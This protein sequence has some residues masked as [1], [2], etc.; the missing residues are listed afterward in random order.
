MNRDR[1]HFCSSPASIRVFLVNDRSHLRML[2]LLTLALVA[3]WMV[4]VTAAGAAVV[5]AMHCPA[6]HMPCCPPSQNGTAQCMASECIEQVP[7]KAEARLDVQVQPVQLAA[8]VED[9][10]TQ[11]SP[12]PPRELHSGLRFHATVFRLK[13]D[14]RI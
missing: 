10:P 5:P 3:V 14:L 1:H 7:Q 12:E 8:P 2:R 6:A 11:P 9:G 13:D 4:T